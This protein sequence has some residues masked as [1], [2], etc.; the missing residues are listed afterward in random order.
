MKLSLEFITFAAL[1]SCHVING[2]IDDVAWVT[3]KVISHVI[4]NKISRQFNE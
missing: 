2:N 1:L 4:A 3:Y